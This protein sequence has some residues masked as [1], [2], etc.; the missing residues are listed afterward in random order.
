[1][2]DAFPDLPVIY[3]SVPLYVNRRDVHFY[4]DEARSAG[5][6]V[7]EVGCGTGRILLPIARSGHTIEGLDSSP[8]MLARCEAK[9]RAE[10]DAVRGRVTLHEGDARSFDLR[11]RFE[12]VIAPF[13]VVQHLTTI[14]AQLGFLSSVAKH[15]APGGRFAFDVFNPYFAKLVSADGKEREDTP[16]TP[17]EDGRSFRRS[18]RVSGVRWIDQ[19]SEV[20]LIYYISTEPGGKAERHVQAFDMR[21]FLRAELVHLLARAGFEVRSIYGDFDRSP[22]KETSPELIVCAERVTA[23]AT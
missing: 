20:E 3:D 2:Y 11:R 9:L 8:Q 19:V 13:R 6:R 14:D 16:D 10:S 21:W 23:V 4:V 12:L 1:M 5:G 22:L 7:L 15:L 17:L 18:A